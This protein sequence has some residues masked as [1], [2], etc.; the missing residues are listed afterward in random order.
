[1]KKIY[2]ARVVR[3][4]VKGV[5]GIIFGVIWTLT[6]IEEGNGQESTKDTI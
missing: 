5:V 4:C 1:M 6:E 3:K 2:L